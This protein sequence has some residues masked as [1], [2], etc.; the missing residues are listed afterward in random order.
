L[1]ELLEGTLL[2]DDLS[3]SSGGWIPSGGF[4]LEEL[5]A[6]ALLDVSGFSGGFELLEDFGLAGSLLLEEL[7]FFVRSELEELLLIC[8]ELEESSCSW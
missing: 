7:L 1:K 8:S 3:F 5:L 4:S 2:D 6:G